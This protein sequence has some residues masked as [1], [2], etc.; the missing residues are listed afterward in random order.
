MNLTPRELE[1]LRRLCDGRNAKGVAHDI[2]ISVNTMKDYSQ[3]IRWKL[4]AKNLPHA[5]AKAVRA[6]L[7]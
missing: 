3:S 5:A 4:G 7:V 2:G 6:G 1:V